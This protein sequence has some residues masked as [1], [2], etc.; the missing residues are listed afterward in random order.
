MI[1]IG[2]YIY[3]DEL[4]GWMGKFVS[5]QVHYYRILE[6]L[7]HENRWDGE[8]FYKE[9]ADFELCLKEG[10]IK[11]ISEDEFKKMQ[12]KRTLKDII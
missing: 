11:I 4:G 1:E 7:P 3:E 10:L 6:Y 2:T 5:K 12:I 9:D 8:A